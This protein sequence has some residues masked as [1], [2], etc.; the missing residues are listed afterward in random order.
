MKPMCCIDNFCPH[1]PSLA[2]SNP[3][4]NTTYRRMRMDY[5]ETL[6]REETFELMICNKR[7]L[8]KGTT[9]KIDVYEVVAIWNLTY[10]IGVIIFCRNPSLPALL[11]KPLEIRYVKFGNVPADKSCTEK[12][13]SVRREF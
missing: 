2:R 9:S 3:R 6:F 13:L 7:L 4:K 10:S 1:A 11:F 8:R 5:V 12:N